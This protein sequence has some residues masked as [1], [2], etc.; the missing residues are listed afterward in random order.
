MSGNYLQI[1][2]S[3]IGNDLVVISANNESLERGNTNY[4]PL[5]SDY[6]RYLESLGWQ[7]VSS[8]TL[9]LNRIVY[10]FKGGY[11]YKI[12]WDGNRWYGVD[13]SRAYE[14]GDF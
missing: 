7:M 2:V 13:S 12:R 14:F 6:F 1:I 5:T 10:T 8:N 11:G 3:Q 4:Y 9:S